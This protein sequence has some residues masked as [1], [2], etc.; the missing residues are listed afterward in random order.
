MPEWSVTRV[1][2]GDTLRVRQG[3]T[4]ERIRLACIDAPELAQPLG[5]ESRDALQALIDQAGGRVGLNVVAQDRY[6]RQIAEVYAG[7]QLAQQVLLQTGMAYVY[8]QYVNR[9]ADPAALKEA[10]S[11]A[12]Q[13]GLGV[14]SGEHQKPWQ[15]RRAN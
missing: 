12:R 4:E 8:P 3:N 9:C 10:E 15:F 14:W 5:P 7:G 2:D 11:L 6:G 13:Q 1:H